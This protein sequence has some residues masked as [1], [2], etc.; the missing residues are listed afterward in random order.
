MP[1]TWQVIRIS[2]AQASSMATSLNAAQTAVNA[3]PATP[4]LTDLVAIR[5]NLKVAIDTL[6]GLLTN[7]TG[8]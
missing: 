4:G 8:S 3:L 7:V 5:D 1:N 2:A 6:Q